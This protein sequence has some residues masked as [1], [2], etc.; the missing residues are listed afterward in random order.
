MPEERWAAAG[1]RRP[2][3]GCE[4]AATGTGLL[5]G[6]YRAGPGGTGRK[7]G[8]LASGDVAEPGWRAALTGAGPDPAHLRGFEEGKGGLLGHGFRL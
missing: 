7:E 2:G 6:R 3:A 1:E 8:A 4:P 5:P